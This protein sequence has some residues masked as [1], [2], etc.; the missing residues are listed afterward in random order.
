MLASQRPCRQLVGA[1]CMAQAYA[2][3]I[4]RG[5]GVELLGNHPRGMLGPHHPAGADTQKWAMPAKKP[6]LG[7]VPA[8]GP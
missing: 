1:K 2:A 8:P 7:G 4:L 6:D 3:G 5:E